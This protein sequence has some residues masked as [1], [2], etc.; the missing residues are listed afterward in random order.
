MY[1]ETWFWKF[2]YSLSIFGTPLFAFAAPEF[3]SSV[4]ALDASQ[5]FG[6]KTLKQSPTTHSDRKL[7]KT[8]RTQTAVYFAFFTA[9]Y[10]VPNIIIYIHSTCIYIVRTCTC[11]HYVGL[12]INTKSIFVRSIPFVKNLNHTNK[13][14]GNINFWKL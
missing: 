1:L 7:I 4:A 6:V 10:N 5:V 2:C 14:F 3:S 13:Y 9:W 11:T 12:C 8:W